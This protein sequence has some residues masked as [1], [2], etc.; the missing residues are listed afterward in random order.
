LRTRKRLRAATGIMFDRL[1]TRR[2]RHL[3][4]PGLDAAATTAAVKV[5]SAGSWIVD[6][7]ESINAAAPLQAVIG[8]VSPTTFTF[9]ATGLPVVRRGQNG[10]RWPATIPVIIKPTTNA[11]TPTTIIQKKIV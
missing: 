1:D 5:L 9:G 7:A 4:H 10:K 6:R 3:P 8:A 11:G 2:I